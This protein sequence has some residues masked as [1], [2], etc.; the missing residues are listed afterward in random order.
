MKKFISLILIFYSGFLSAQTVGQFRYDTTLFYKTGGFNEVKIQNKTKD[1][2][3]IFTNVGNGWG[4]WKKP[5]VVS[6]GIVIGNDTLMVSGGGGSYVPYTGATGNVNL[7]AFDLTA[8]H[9]IKN[10]GVST[11]FLKADGSI[12]NNAY[13]TSANLPT[14][15]ELFATNTASDIP[16]YFRLVGDIASPHY[17]T[18]AVNIPTGAI[19]IPD[20]LIANLITESNIISGNPGLFNITTVG[21]IRKLTG[22]GTA[23]FYFKVYKRDVLGTETFITTSNNT[24]PPSSAIYSEFSAAALWNDGVF[25]NTDRIV[26]KFYGTRV[27]GGSDPTYEFQFGGLTPVRTIAAIPTAVIPNINIAQLS[28]VEDVAPLNKEALYYN[29]TSELWEHDS[30][31]GIL[32]F[33]PVKDVSSNSIGDSLIVVKNGIRSAY[34][35][36]SGSGVT[37]M[38]APTSI[39]SNG[40]VITGSVLQL[41]Y[42]SPTTPGMVATGNQYFSGLKYFNNGLNAIDYLGI[43][44]SDLSA[45]LGQFWNDG[46]VGVLDIY[47]PAAGATAQLYAN[48]LSLANSGTN[49]GNIS[50]NNLVSSWQYYLPNNNGT[51]ALSVNGKYATSDGNVTLLSEDMPMESSAAWQ[52]AGNSTTIT[53]VG[54]ATLTAAGTATAANIA[55]TNRH[56]QMHRLDYLVTTPT[57][58]AIAGVRSSAAQYFIGNTA[59]SGGFYFAC[60]FGPATGVSVTGNRCFTGMT[61][62]ATA[63]TDIEPSTQTNMIG[64]GWDG[65]DANIQFMRNDGAG[66][67]TKIDLGIAVPIV[68]RTSAYEIIFHCPPNSTTF[69]YTFT[70]LSSGTV[71]SGS[72][73]TDLPAANTLLAPRG[74]ISVGGLTSSVIGYSLSLMRVETSF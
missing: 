46:G 69:T 39:N 58:S 35:Y 8:T 42:A 11:Q 14:S 68:D 29:S 23:V 25:L 41:S 64:V 12:D 65:A 38:G 27:A 24:L 30:I 45:Q 57:T 49:S 19:T 63:P 74:W 34:K 50:A 51:F 6:G 71:A 53:S 59:G 40:A 44:N 22:S 70:D 10:G 21:N 9:L 66:T 17:N 16:T 3:G 43:Y 33:T 18:T 48:F 37:S 55:T 7:G 32:G 13:L 73:N 1:T 61:S 36:P 28:D 26:L 15:L 62:S 47:D 72:V 4:Q 60:R 56:T 31:A 2:L 54:A 20:Q 67:A 5:S 52:A